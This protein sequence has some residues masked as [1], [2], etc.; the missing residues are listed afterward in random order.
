MKGISD[1]KPGDGWRM[2]QTLGEGA[3]TGREGRASPAGP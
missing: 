1:R 2:G 3:D